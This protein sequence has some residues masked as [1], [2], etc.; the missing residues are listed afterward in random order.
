LTLIE[1]TIAISIM[2]VITVLGWRSLDTLV[3]ARSALSSE[4][5]L[6]RDLQLTFSQ[7]QIDC[8]Q[9]VEV[10]SLPWMALVAEKNRLTLVR[11]ESVDRQPTR[12][13]VVSYRLRNGILTRLASPPTRDISVLYAD[14]LAAEVQ[15][16][17]VPG[18]R[19]HAN[20]GEMHMRV[21]SNDSKGWRS[22]EILDD[23]AA[24]AAMARA[25]GFADLA[26][27]GLEISITEAGQHVP[28][29]KILLLGS[30]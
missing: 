21:W 26:Y 11:T 7:M 9:M 30:I 1:L 16:N 6:T 3:R 12:L 18:L 28:V 14:W 4:L 10:T 19:L 8:A 20:V 22:M 29:T 24:A 13:A 2:A 23:E 25:T 17:E 15:T 5:A 27:T